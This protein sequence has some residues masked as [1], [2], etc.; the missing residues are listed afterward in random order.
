MF[1]EV[2]YETGIN[3]VA[4][5]DTEDEALSALKAHTDRAKAGLSGGPVGAPHIPAARVKKALV[6]DKHP[7]DYNVEQTLS[8]DEV[9]AALAD[10]VKKFSDK[11]GVVNVSVLADEVRG[12]T[13]PMVNSGPQESNF[14]M[15]ESK[16]LDLSYLEGSADA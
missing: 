14:K 8:A 10:L 13:H 7:N 11:N 5:Y 4:C 12:L 3:S 1:V 6:Y 16:E 2:I 15:Q 9:S